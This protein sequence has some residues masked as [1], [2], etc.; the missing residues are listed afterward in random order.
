MLQVKRDYWKTDH[1]LE[2]VF[3]VPSCC[4]FISLTP[5]SADLVQGFLPLD[6]G[7]GASFLCHS[8]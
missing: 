7:G 8:R 4:H 6:V 1:L 3:M 5:I 2:S